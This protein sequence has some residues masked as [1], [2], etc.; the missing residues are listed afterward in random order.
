[1][2]NRDE[3]K[4][5]IDLTDYMNSI[6]IDV[7]KNYIKKHFLTPYQL[8]IKGAVILEKLPLFDNVYGPRSPNWSQRVEEELELF[9]F[10]KEKYIQ[11]IGFPVYDR[12]RQVPG[13]KRLWHAL[14]RMNKRSKGRKIEIRL[15]LRYPYRFPRAKRDVKE[16][17]VSLNDKCL[18]ELVQRWRSDGKFGIPHFLVILGYYYALEHNSVKI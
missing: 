12:L 5:T 10:L 14:F 11:Q 7:H 16:R 4:S 3:D 13:N 18:G 1:M 8:K 2:S 15:D 6:S 17:H 9:K